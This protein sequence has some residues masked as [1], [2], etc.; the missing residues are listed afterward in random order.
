MTPYEVI[1]IGPM[2]VVRKPVSLPPADGEIC[3]AE[4]LTDGRRSRG[5]GA[6]L[7]A[8][9]WQRLSGQPLGWEPTHWTFMEAG[10]VRKR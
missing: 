4:I 7:V 10:H 9:E 2:R 5:A 6:R 8:G 3:F 1:S